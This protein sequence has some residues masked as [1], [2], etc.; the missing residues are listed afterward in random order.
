M[1][2]DKLTAIAVGILSTLGF[3]I[4]VILLVKIILLLTFGDAFGDTELRICF[5]DPSGGEGSICI[6]D[7]VPS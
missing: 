6:D 7:G 4:M 3:I 5:P 2:I 1:T